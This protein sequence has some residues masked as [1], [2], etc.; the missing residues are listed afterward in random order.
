MYDSTLNST[1]EFFFFTTVLLMHK[2]YIVC[3][4][5]LLF[6]LAR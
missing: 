6:A 2:L 1:E 3:P 4:R 5:V